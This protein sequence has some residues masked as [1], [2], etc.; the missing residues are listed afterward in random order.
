[1]IYGFQTWKLSVK[2]LSLHP[3]RSMLTVLGIFIGVMGLITPFFGVDRF[4]R[5]LDWWSALGPGFLRVW[6]AFA[7]VLDL[8][9]AYAVAP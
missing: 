6:G 9:L 1:M 3:L 8:L 4:R 7:L 2:S 5:L